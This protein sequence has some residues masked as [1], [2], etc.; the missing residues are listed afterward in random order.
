MQGLAQQVTALRPQLVNSDATFGELAWIWGKD[1]AVLADTWR[2][3]LWYDGTDL[4][5]WGWIFLPYRVRR[6]D[7]KDLHVSSTALTWQ[8]HPSQPGILDQIL[9]WY[10]AEA[11]QPARG[12][13]VRAAD[14][15]AVGR[16]AAHGYQVDEQASG[17]S[18]FWTQFNA[19]DLDGVPEPVLPPGFRLL[20]ADQVT[21][22][23]AAQAHRDAWHPSSFT[24]RGMRDVRQTWP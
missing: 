3:R 1:H 10:E 24:D 22:E 16:L 21:P 4:A 8:V 12:V 17:D 11:P 7:G 15:D 9:D 20:T 23:A 5:G 18:G 6:S 19:R 13:T 14:S 2:H